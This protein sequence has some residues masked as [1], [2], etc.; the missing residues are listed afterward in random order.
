MNFKSF[1]IAEAIIRLLK[2]ANKKKLIAELVAKVEEISRTNLGPRSEKVQLEVIR[3][4]LLPLCGELTKDDA[5][6]TRQYREALALEFA[7]VSKEQQGNSQEV[8]K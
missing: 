5:E 1:V 8:V 7:R 4:V 2:D 6:S 3:N